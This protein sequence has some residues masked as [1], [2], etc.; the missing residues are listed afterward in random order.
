MPPVSGHTKSSME[1]T[2]KDYKE[3]HEWLDMDPDKK[4]ERHDITKIYE[5]GK[6]IE[7]QY[8]KEGL[9]EYIRHLHDDIK[10]KFNHLQHDLEKQIA[11]TLAYFGIKQ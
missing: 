4:A 3:V 8:G 2:G 5:Y 6:F 7:E 11:D 1:R 9:Q 10:A